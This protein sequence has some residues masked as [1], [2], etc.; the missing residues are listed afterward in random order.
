MVIEE[1]L[2]S[3]FSFE[4]GGHFLMAPCKKASSLLSS[5]EALSL[6]F[7]F[8]IARVTNFLLNIITHYSC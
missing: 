4:P 7:N 2:N 8:A 3:Y 1:M 6:V 5:H